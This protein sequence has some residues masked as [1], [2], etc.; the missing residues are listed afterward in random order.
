MR[1]KPFIPEIYSGDQ[2]FVRNQTDGLVW[3]RSYCRTLYADT[4]RSAVVYHANYL[5]YFEFGRATLM[6]DLDYPYI[7]IENNGYVYPIVELGVK[8]Q[9]PLYYDDPMWINT[10]PGEMERV[11]LRFYYI[12]TQAQTGQIVCSGFTDHC[13]LNASGWPVAIDEN[14]RQL[15]EIF[16][17]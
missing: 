16:P 6:R 10:R 12:I 1:P 11:K 5:R 9:S 3:H 7:E 4:D 8:Y 2:R 17:T 14:T 13:A 15:W